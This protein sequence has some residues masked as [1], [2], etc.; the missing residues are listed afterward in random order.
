MAGL[1]VRMEGLDM[2]VTTDQVRLVQARELVRE[3]YS[4]L[5]SAEDLIKDLSDETTKGWEY[6]GQ[7]VAELTDVI[8]I[9]ASLWGSVGIW[10]AKAC[11]K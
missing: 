2:T 6:F 3:A 4:K 8:D 1:W 11:E 5:L 9:L 7:D 10:A